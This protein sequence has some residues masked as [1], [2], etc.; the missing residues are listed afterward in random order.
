LEIS[1]LRLSKVE[2]E[3]V[4]SFE[5]GADDTRGRISHAIAAFG[6]YGFDFIRSKARGAEQAR[7]GLP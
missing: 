3:E 6:V 2:G 5:G 1:V 4:G 7:R